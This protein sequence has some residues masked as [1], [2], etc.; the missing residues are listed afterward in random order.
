MIECGLM[1]GGESLVRY[2]RTIPSQILVTDIDMTWKLVSHPILLKRMRSDDHPDSTYRTSNRKVPGQRRPSIATVSH[3][4][5]SF[6]WL[7][8]VEERISS[9]D[10]QDITRESSAISGFSCAFLSFSCSYYPGWYPG[11]AVEKDL[12]S[13]RTNEAS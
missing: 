9:T 6:V 10:S 4:T 12:G 5:S 3:V 7:S 2:S 11:V 8:K 13:N 1:Q